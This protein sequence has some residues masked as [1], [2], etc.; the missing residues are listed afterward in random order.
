MPTKF[1]IQGS[2]TLLQSLIASQDVQRDEL[3]R[4][5]H[6]N[7]NQ[8]LASARL[9]LEVAQQ[10]SGPDNSL[11]EKG[12]QYLNTAI[13]EIRKITRSLNTAAVEDV[14]LE[15]AI[16]Q[17]LATGVGGGPLNAGVDYDNRLNDALTPAIKLMVYRILQEQL[18]NIHRYAAAGH[19]SVT[20]MKTGQSLYYSIT[21]DGRGFNV[22]EPAKGM[23]FIVIQN[24]V[25][26]FNGTFHL[27]SAPGKGCRLEIELP[28]P[29]LQE[30]R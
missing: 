3:G 27:Y 20:L 10:D 7:V 16:R 30:L 17:L 1:S 26:A 2:S 15:A 25:A 6:N 11:L 23:G 13:S 5:L 21:D 8:L 9:L 24:R 28:L 19:I 12:L 14:G 22:N 18:Q 29:V 4:E